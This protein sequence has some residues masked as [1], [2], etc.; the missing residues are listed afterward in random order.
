MVPGGFEAQSFIAQEGYPYPSVFNPTGDIRDGLGL[1]GQPDTIFF[2][3]TGR[4]VDI[5]SGAIGFPELVSR[6]H[7]ILP[8]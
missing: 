3:A 1:I 6:I 2:D 7:K 5:W 8:G 4:Q